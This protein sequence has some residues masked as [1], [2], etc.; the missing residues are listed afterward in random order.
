MFVVR[1][2][3]GEKEDINV[4][5]NMNQVQ[6]FYVSGKCIIFLLE[7]RSSS[8][9][10]FVI[11]FEYSSYKDALAAYSSILGALQKRCDTVFYLPHE[12]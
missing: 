7:L 9:D 3:G 6:S 2:V 10:D 4:T 11:E 12:L 1:K 8:E 5:I